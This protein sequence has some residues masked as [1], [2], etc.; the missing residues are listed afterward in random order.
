MAF[1]STGCCC[2]LYK[3]YLRCKFEG[4]SSKLPVGVRKSYAGTANAGSEP[5]PISETTEAITALRI[6]IEVVFIKDEED[7]AGD[8]H[9]TDSTAKKQPATAALNPLSRKQ[10]EF[11]SDTNSLIMEIK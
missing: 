6:T 5:R 1:N 7:S 3:I 11:Q 9:N 8:G 10:E 2:K 4:T